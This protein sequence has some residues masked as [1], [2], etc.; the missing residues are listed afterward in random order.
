MIIYKYVLEI[1]DRQ[2]IQLGIK[3]PVK[4]LSV[5]EQKGN[6]VMWVQLDDENYNSFASDIE[7]NVIGTGNKFRPDG[8]FIGTVIM[9]YG[10]VW[11][12]FA[13]TKKR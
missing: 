12:V 8:D 13:R 9:S 4:V 11:H 1:A 7:V 6:L 2:I 10:L 5:A 3:N